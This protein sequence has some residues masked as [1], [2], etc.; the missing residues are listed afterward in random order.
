MMFIKISYFIWGLPF[1]V[2]FS[3]PAHAYLDPG[4][5]S[6]IVQVI[7]GGIAAGMTAMSF[8]WSKVKDFINRHM[9]SKSDKNSSV[10]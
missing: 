1:L 6:L 5:G 4:T 2:F 3:S 8:Y 7:I 10:D 9:K